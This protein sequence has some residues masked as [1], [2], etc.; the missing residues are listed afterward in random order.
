[1]E[2]LQS[3]TNYQLTIGVNILETKSRKVKGQGTF[4][5]SVG[6]NTVCGIILPFVDQYI[7][8]IQYVSKYIPVEISTRAGSASG[9]CHLYRPG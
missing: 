6:Q 8:C 1:M 3:I 4:S 7:C 9:R 5:F 2:V